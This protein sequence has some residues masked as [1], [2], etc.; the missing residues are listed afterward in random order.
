MYLRHLHVP[1]MH[2]LFN[3][4]QPYSDIGIYTPRPPY[5][6]LP[7][8]NDYTNTLKKTFLALYTYDIIL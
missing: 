1:R 5:I 8:G 6:V 2:I 3:T 4:V 7:F